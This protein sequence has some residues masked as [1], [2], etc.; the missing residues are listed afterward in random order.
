MNSVQGT[1]YPYLYCVILAKNTSSLFKRADE[2]SVKI[3]YGIM[4]QLEH[5]QDVLVMVIRQMTTKTSGYHTNSR[6]ALKI[7]QATVDYTRELLRS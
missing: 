7:V 4:H 5:S 1:D 2:L 3:P 6:A